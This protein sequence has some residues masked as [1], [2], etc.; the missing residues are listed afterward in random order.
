MSTALR[1]W[2]IPHPA[3]GYTSTPGSA[4]VMLAATN[5]SVS[6]PASVVAAIATIQVQDR[7]IDV[8]LDPYRAFVLQAGEHPLGSPET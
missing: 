2:L 8:G 7:R 3:V 5:V 6:S 4:V 1:T